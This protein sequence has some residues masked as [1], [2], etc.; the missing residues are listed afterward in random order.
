MDRL[1]DHLF[2]FEGEGKIKDFPGN[3]TDFREWEKEQKLAPKLEKPE[4]KAPEPKKVEAASVSKPKATF[5]DK[6]EFEE[7]SNKI[8]SLQREKDQLVEKIQAGSG[9]PAD[10][11]N[12]SKRIVAIDH[13]VENLEMRWLELS[14]LEGIG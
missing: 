12:W 2:V 9:G 7:T 6:K 11:T 1:V 13:E 10:M 14:E 3:Y 8:E 5:K 4:V